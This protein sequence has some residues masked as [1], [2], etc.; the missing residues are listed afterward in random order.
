MH[1]KYC[2]LLIAYCLLNL[3]HNNSSY[4]FSQYIPLFDQIHVNVLMNF[5]V[6]LT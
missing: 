3:L 5:K 6:F 1:N 2:L 4:F